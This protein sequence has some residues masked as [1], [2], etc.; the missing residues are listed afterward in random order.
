MF[1]KVI[2][3][4]FIKVMRGFFQTTTSKWINKQKQK[5]DWQ[6]PCRVCLLTHLQIKPILSFTLLLHSCVLYY[7]RERTFWHHW[8]VAVRVSG[9]DFSIPLLVPKPH[10]RYCQNLDPTEP[11]EVEPCSGPCLV[12]GTYS[13]GLASGAQQTLPSFISLS[14]FS[15]QLAV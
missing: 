11:C 4:T 15:L 14:F 6:D 3:T 8:M 12:Q 5:N 1:I 10:K 9:L 2:V 7:G 13:C